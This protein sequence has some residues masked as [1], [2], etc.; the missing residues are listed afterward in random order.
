MRMCTRIQTEVGQ[1]CESC[2]HGLHMSTLSRQMVYQ[3]L[4]ISTLGL[5]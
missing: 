2:V 1:D 4:S 5:K 3:T